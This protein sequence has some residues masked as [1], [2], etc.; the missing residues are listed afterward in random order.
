MALL[1]TH[2]LENGVSIDYWAVKQS[3]EFDYHA[4][5]CRLWVLA[6]VS[7]QAKDNGSSYVFEATRDYYVN[8]GDFNTYFSDAVLKMEGNSFAS[9]AYAYLKEKDPFFADAV[10]I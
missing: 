2:A 9:Q 6:W 5:V 8:V 1:K 3:T 10:E 7:K 4:Q